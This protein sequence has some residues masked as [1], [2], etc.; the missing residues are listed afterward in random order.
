MLYRPY[1]HRKRGAEASLWQKEAIGKVRTAADGL[2]TV[3]T[4]TIAAD[5]VFFADNHL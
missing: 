1:L 2:T 5:L 4:K 3:M